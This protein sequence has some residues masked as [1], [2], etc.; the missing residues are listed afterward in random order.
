VARQLAVTADSFTAACTRL[1]DVESALPVNLADAH[2]RP[3]L[4]PI[5]FAL[6]PGSQVMVQGFADLTNAAC[7]GLTL[8]VVSAGVVSVPPALAPDTDANQ[9]PD[10]WEA[11]FLAGAGADPNADPDGDGYTNLRELLD[12]TD[13]TD[14]LSHGLEPPTW[15]APAL[16]LEMLPTGQIHLHWRSPE[17]YAQLVRFVVRSTDQLGVPFADEH[18]PV[19][20]LGGGEFLVLLPLTSTQRFYQLQLLPR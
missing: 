12:G 8:E 13:P 9:L 6:P 16:A 18:I 1:I 7:P 5:T 14:P 20:H 4:F 10:P 3:F 19:T 15:Q 2:G 17:S 11:L